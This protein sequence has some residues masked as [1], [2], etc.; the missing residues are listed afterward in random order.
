MSTAEQ[1]EIVREMHQDFLA[2]KVENDNGRKADQDKL[3]K[4]NGALNERLD[5]IEVAF[6]RTGT[7]VGTQEGVDETKNALAFEGICRGAPVDPDEATLDVDQY[8]AYAKA[9]GRYLRRG[10]AKLREV[11]K[12]ALEVGEAKA[13]STAIQADGGYWVVPEMSDR[14]VTR[15]FE[16]SPIRSLASV[17]T[18]GTSAFEMPT[19]TN[20]AVTGGWI[21]EKGSRPETATPEV[22][23]LRIPVH[24]QYAFPMATQNLLDDANI[25]AEGWLADKIADKLVRDENVA[26][27]TGNGVDRPKG[28]TDYS[29][30][31]VTAD[32]AS[33]AWG[34]LQYVATGKS[35][36]FDDGTVD[37]TAAPS[38]EL[39]DLVYR[40]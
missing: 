18:I 20:D 35:A 27:V 24:E 11:D 13:L 26:F 30:T 32:D 9:F 17:I 28:F 19:D 31:A 40:L 8:R 36:D 38:V 39:I 16:T 2:F 5:Q 14:I 7:R 37:A 1:V 10:E 34:V 22:G 3:D 4:I 12:A 21:G 6:K 29:S 23:T 15:Q 33:R 25:D